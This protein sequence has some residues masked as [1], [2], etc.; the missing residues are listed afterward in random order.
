MTP[1]VFVLC[2]SS[3]NSHNRQPASQLRARAWISKTRAHA[4][5]HVTCKQVQNYYLLPMQ[6][7]RTSSQLPC[8]FACLPASLT[9]KFP[10]HDSQKRGFEFRHKAHLPRRPPSSPPSHVKCKPTAAP[11]RTPA[12][13]IRYRT[14]KCPRM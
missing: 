7:G 11:P 10:P 5:H 9:G 12:S 14:V 1:V 8:L 2:V 13:H 3:S 4:T 6:L